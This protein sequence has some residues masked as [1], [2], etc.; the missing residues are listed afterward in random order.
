[1]RQPGAHLKGVLPLDW[2]QHDRYK[3]KRH[4]LGFVVQYWLGMVNSWPASELSCALVSLGRLGLYAD[5]MVV[6]T[7]PARAWSDSN[8]SRCGGGK[9]AWG[10]SSC[11]RRPPT[12][13]AMERTLS[14]ACTVYS[15]LQGPLLCRSLRGC[16]RRCWPQTPACS[17]AALHQRRWI[18]QVRSLNI[19][20]GERSPAWWGLQGPRQ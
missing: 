10:P 2:M 3:T 13:A 17:H 15:R 8:V 19:L 12:L 11:N 9:G 20:R 18:E 6:P 1:M 14:A 7:P 16:W 4:S 5:T